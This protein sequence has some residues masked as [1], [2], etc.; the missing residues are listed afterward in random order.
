[1]KQTLTLVLGLWIAGSAAAQEISREEIR[2]TP[3]PGSDTMDVVVM[4]LTVPPG[5][6]VPL[7]TH[8]GD[9]HAVVI[10]PT[11]AKTP[12]G[13]LVEFAVGTSLYFPEG[14]V[15]GGLTNMGDA[16]MVAITT[17]I[18]RK[19]APFSTLVQN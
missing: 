7:H 10:T 18:V 14:Q 8:A 1:M 11:K 17:S 2:R 5:A 13:D 3:V 12:G 15:H 16:P 19:D 9:E 6:T 4:R